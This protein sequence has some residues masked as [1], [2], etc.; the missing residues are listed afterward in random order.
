MNMSFCQS[1]ARLTV[2]CV[3]I[4]CVRTSLLHCLISRL[5]TLAHSSAAPPLPLPLAGRLDAMHVV[6]DQHLVSGQN[7]QS[8][9]T[10]VQNLILLS[11]AW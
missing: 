4:L 7:E 1:F 3:C 9:L 5:L 10:A 6:V 2:C 8:T 11:N